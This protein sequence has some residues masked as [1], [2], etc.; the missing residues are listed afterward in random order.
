MNANAEELEL[1]D[2][3]NLIENMIAQGRR[4]TQSWGWSFVLWG[5]AYYVAIA[6]ATWARFGLA[7][8]I[9]MTAAGILT[10][11]FIVRM[12]G[13]RPPTTMGR[14]ISSIWCSMGISMFILLDAMGFRAPHVDG[15]IMIAVASTMIGTAN[16]ASSM[17]LRWKAQFACAV[18]WWAAAVVSC[19]GTEA[20]GAIAFLTAIF[21]C[22]IVFGVYCM[23]R[24]AGERKRRNG[25]QGAAHA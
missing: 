8:P 18:A 15:N 2:R 9:T 10:G 23:I 3:L 7:W 25:I 6:W 21:L 19:F 5:V 16:A 13:N 4:T 17:A 11:F 14:A 12:R 22:Q 24:E 1:K 20:Q